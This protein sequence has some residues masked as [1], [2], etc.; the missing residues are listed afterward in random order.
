MK[1]L[2][3]IP[4]AFYKMIETLVSKV[5]PS[6]YHPM[7]QI[8]EDRVIYIHW[9]APRFLPI[10][11]ISFVVSYHKGYTPPQQKHMHITRYHTISNYL[12]CNQFKGHTEFKPRM[13]INPSKCLICKSEPRI[14]VLCIPDGECLSL[15]HC[16]SF[17]NRSAY[18]IPCNAAHPQVVKIPTLAPYYPKHSGTFTSTRY[19]NV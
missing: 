9:K 8:D 13:D 1:R 2:A 12:I 19:L 16:S 3:S 15:F 10:F 7:I 6:F 17:C 5:I 18:I 14:L 11:L 4:R